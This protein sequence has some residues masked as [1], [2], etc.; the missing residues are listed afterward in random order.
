MAFVS[1]CGGVDKAIE[2]QRVLR[3][4]LLQLWM[5]EAGRLQGSKKGR[6]GR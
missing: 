1:Q 4:Q 6:T 5:A 2:G 3:R